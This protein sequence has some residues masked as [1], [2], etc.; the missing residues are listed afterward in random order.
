MPFFYIFGLFAVSA[1]FLQAVLGFVQI[2][3]FTKVYREMRRQGRVAI[4]RKA[5]KIQA[6]TIVILALNA[7]G[8]ILEG[9]KIQG[10]TV[11]AK[12]K[13][14]PGIV[15]YQIIELSPKSP[16]IAK[17]NQLTKATIMDAVNGY[18]QCQNGEIIA[19]KTAPCLSLGTKIRRFTDLIQIKLKRSVNK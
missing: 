5:G 2:N 13:K 18:Q 11:F 16:G 1:Y 9:R 4:G 8:M 3:H 7:K 10:T 15:G 17:E 6:G 12:F 19:E 14:I